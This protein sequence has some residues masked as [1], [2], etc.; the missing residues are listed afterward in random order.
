MGCAR[1]QEDKPLRPCNVAAVIDKRVVDRIVQVCES[2]FVFL[3]SY[4][5]YRSS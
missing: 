2:C 5:G 4:H 1:C 3:N